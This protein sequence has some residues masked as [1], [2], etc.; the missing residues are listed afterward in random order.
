MAN[1]TLIGPYSAYAIA[2]K[3]GYQGTEA[4]WAK[5]L[6]DAGNN[7]A[8]AA[9][10]KT[11]AAQSA[12]NAATS[13]TNVAQAEERINTAVSGAVEAVA[14]QETKSVQ[15]I[16][17][18]GEASAAAVTAEGERVLGTIPEDYTTLSNGVSQLKEDIST[19]NPFINNTNL[20][21][22]P[23]LI[24]G[25]GSWLLPEVFSY[26]ESDDICKKIHCISDGVRQ[27]NI[28]QLFPKSIINPG[29]TYTVSVKFSDG[30]GWHKFNVGFCNATIE[31][32]GSIISSNAVSNSGL[33]SFDFTYDVTDNRFEYFV[34][35]ISFTSKCDCYMYE[36]YF[37]VKS[38][39]NSFYNDSINY[40]RIDG[41]RVNGFAELSEKAD[42]TESDLE[43]VAKI[44]DNIYDKTQEFTVGYLQNGK[45]VSIPHIYVS[46]YIKVSAGETLSINKI[47]VKFY[48][49][50]NIKQSVSFF[51]ADKSY[52]GNLEGQTSSIVQDTPSTQ[53]FTFT[54]ID[55]AEYMRVALYKSTVD[56]YIIVK[57]TELTDKPLAY[58]RNIFLFDGWDTELKNAI[59]SPLYQKTVIFNGDSICAAGT[60]TSGNG[61]FAGRIATKNYMT[62]KNYAVGGGT[63][64]KNVV[65]SGGNTKHSVCGTVDTMYSEYPNADYII[66]EGGTNDADL[67]GNAINSTPEKFGTFNLTDYSGTYDEDTFCGALESLFF[68]AIGYWTKK[69]IGYIVAMKMGRSNIGYT[70]DV[71]NRRKY[72]ETAMQICKK[73]GIPYLNLWD[74]CHMNPSLNSCFIPGDT[75]TDEGKSAMHQNNLD[76]GRLYIDGQHPTP[77]GY[78]YL[79]PIIEEWMRGL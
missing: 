39:N 72:F 54:V 56:S 49:L 47:P 11:A 2:V 15:A 58:G 66:F 61:A 33:Y 65:D 70:A 32:I 6:I 63:I 17:A 25:D 38:N 48:G 36:P 68:K 22:N 35:Q 8:S 1:K 51:D 23:C 45:I 64:T 60:D 5:T 41:T 42:T 20:F 79:A 29:E 75:S 40:L 26:A 46:E 77:A 73:W 34:V 30:I 37:G 53:P 57:G 28:N 4:E 59:S 3:H 10:S 44:F 50:S 9:E 52:I 43:S 13:E 71:Y 7:A 24:D 78:D 62:M 18:Q 67:I 12:E 69:K 76:N 74:G 31:S 14:A 55:D 21:K 19:L 27:Y 16:T